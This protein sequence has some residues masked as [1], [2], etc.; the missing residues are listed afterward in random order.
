MVCRFY[1]TTKTPFGHDSCGYRRETNITQWIPLPTSHPTAHLPNSR[2][3]IV[4]SV[5][6][7]QRHAAGGAHRGDD[8][9]LLGRRG[10]RKD[11]GAFDECDQRALGELGCG[12]GRGRTVRT[13]K[14][15]RM[16]NDE[17]DEKNDD[18]DNEDKNKEVKNNEREGEMMVCVERDRS[19]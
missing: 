19:D 14:M 16:R 9:F 15:R 10:A 3:D 7:H 8:A 6:A 17:K 5:A 12:G 1:T 13:M 11:G 4:G 18:E 2:T